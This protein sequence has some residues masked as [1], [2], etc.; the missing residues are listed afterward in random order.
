MAILDA[1]RHILRQAVANARADMEIYV[2][3]KEQERARALMHG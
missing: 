1:K 2:A 3:R